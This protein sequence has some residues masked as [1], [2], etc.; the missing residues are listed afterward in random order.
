MHAQFGEKKT[1]GGDPTYGRKHLQSLGQKI[2]RWHDCRQASQGGAQSHGLLLEAPYPELATLIRHA[3]FEGGFGGG[4]QSAPVEQ[5]RHQEQTDHWDSEAQVGQ[6]E[7]WQQ[8]NGTSTEKTQ[9]TT[10]ADGAVV[11]YIYQA[12]AIKAM[13][14]QRI[15]RVAERTTVRTMTIRLRKILLILLDGAAER[16]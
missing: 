2:S 9:I 3:G 11:L 5:A 8:R 13:R 6:D 15:W 12:A 10:H 16:V 7:L 14:S 1:M 4:S